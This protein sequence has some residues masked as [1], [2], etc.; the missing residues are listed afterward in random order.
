M[1]ELRNQSFRLDDEETLI[2]E[3]YMR[4]CL[5]KLL[6]QNINGSAVVYGAWHGPV[7]TQSLSKTI[8]REK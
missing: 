5:R 8:S 6:K 1:A 4:Q 7:L 3:Q 2:R